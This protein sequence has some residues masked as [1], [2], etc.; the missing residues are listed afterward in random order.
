MK[1]VAGA[2]AA[3]T[4]LAGVVYAQEGFVTPFGAP[5]AAPQPTAAT[6]PTS[7]PAPTVIQPPPAP[8]APQAVPAGGA[9]TPL[10]P[11][12]EIARLRAGIAA[13]DAADWTGLRSARAAATDPLV[14]RIL[15]WRLASDT[16]A[17]ASFD[18]IKT[19]LDQL[20]NWPGR[21]TMRRRAEQQIFD[22]ALTYNQRVAWLQSG[23]PISGDGK[24]ALAQSLKAIGRSAEANSVIRQTWR[25][26]ILTPRA[27]QIALMEFGSVLSA[28]DHGARV[29]WA[30]WRDDRATANRL[31]TRLGAEGRLVAQARIALQTRPRKGLQ[32]AVDRVPSSRTEDAGLLYDRVRYIRRDGRPEDA[33]PIAARIAAAGTPIV[34]R[35]ALFK[36]RRLYVPR[37]LKMGDRARAYRLVADHGL[38]QGESFADAEWLAGWLALRFTRD[39]ASADRHF[40]KMDANVSAPVSKAR[41]LYWRAMA[42]KALNQNDAAQLLLAEAAKFNFTYYGQI[43]A[44]KV[45][46]SPV[47][48]LGERS[49]VTPAA[50]AEFESRE[51]V[52]ALKLMAEAGDQ[53]DFESIAFYLDDQMSTP[54]EHELLSLIARERAYTRTAVRSAK[55]GMRRGIIAPDAAYPLLDLPADARKPGRPE[56]ALI[57]AITRQESEFDPRAHS[58]A[59]ARGLMQIMPATARITARTEGLPYQ[60]NWLVDDPSY[61]VTLGA[62]Y[63]QHLLEQWNGSYVLTIASYNA[64]PGRPREWIG[65][66]GDPR[67]AS[68]DVIDWV[69]LIPFSE[70]RN[71]VQRV[72]EN[73]QVYRHRIAGTPVPL[74]IE[75]D[76]RRGAY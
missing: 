55:A 16:N 17:P 51:V 70:T 20:V 12:A 53:R 75:Q 10:P 60:P 31:M 2:L 67:A 5:S 74:R 29:D 30:L 68:T 57:L 6:A 41:A 69:E 28:A 54:L 56:P 49:L 45:E 44:S 32:A 23:G 18:E 27:E 50:R 59:G 34:A 13:A 8:P 48:S 66:W 42:G 22:S 52:R 39:P 47:L 64:G 1:G 21:E 14:R 19:A 11:A 61:N 72:L 4:L 40:T 24:V 7:T 63:L 76:L 33:L 36:E 3:A 58:S 37:A 71:Y 25:E 43:A 26:N 38:A 15:Q 65:D 62:A 73:V 46:T 35:E 9:A